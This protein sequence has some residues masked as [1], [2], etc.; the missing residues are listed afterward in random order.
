MSLAD[1]LGFFSSATKPREPEWRKWGEVT[2]SNLKIH[3][4]ER[5][6]VRS[7]ISVASLQTGHSVAPSHVAKLT[8]TFPRISPVY[9]ATYRITLIKDISHG[10]HCPM[11]PLPGRLQNL[12]R[13]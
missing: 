9:I 1:K 4:R 2:G 13:E 11:K 6:G 8:D 7:E 5:A 3:D 10:R 12:D